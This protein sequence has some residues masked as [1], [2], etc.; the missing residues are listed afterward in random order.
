MGIFD[1]LMV[2]VLA[3]HGRVLGLDVGG[4]ATKVVIF[5]NGRLV[6]RSDAVAGNVL[7]DVDLAGQLA[8]VVQ[9]TRPDRAGIGLAG[10]SDN[11]IAASFGQA[12]TSQCHLP[13]VAATDIATAWLG[14]FLGGPG[15]VVAAGTGSFA[16]GG[17][18]LNN[19]YRAGGHGF[20][21]GDE[22]S[23][24][25]LGREAVK[26]ALA[27][28]DGTGPPTS[29]SILI[30]EKTGYELDEVVRLVYRRPSDRSF[31]SALAPAIAAAADGTPPGEPGDQVAQGLLEAAAGALAL[32]AGSLQ[33]RLGGLPVAAVGGVLDGSLRRYLERRLPLQAPLADPGVGAALLAVSPYSP[34]PWL[35]HGAQGAGTAG[36]V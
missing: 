27:A 12:I 24:Y 26:A 7:L 22:G 20:I 4:S 33:R 2:E 10:A 18:D 19:L 13:V 3:G 31:L 25:W 15:I 1:G 35:P 6:E 5:E 21:L 23:A 17:H 16:V 30:R 11:L 29:L 28:Q 36:R 14:A 8:A 32:L 34:G 9:R